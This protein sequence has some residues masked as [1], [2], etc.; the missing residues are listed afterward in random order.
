MPI[1]KIIIH[2]ETIDKMV[3]MFNA[4]ERDGFMKHDP[5]FGP[6]KVIVTRDGVTEEIPTYQ[7]A[8]TDLPRKFILYNIGDPIQRDKIRDAN[9]TVTYLYQIFRRWVNTN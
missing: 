3:E 1:H 7:I 5:Q 8:V 4:I 9:G 6:D 2:Q